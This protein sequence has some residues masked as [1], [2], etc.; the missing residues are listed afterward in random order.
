MQVPR[1]DLRPASF[2]GVPFGVT[3]D[4][5]DT[6]RR[7]VKHE[8]PGREKPYVEDLGRKTRG[9]SIEAFVVGADYADR[10]NELL[11]ALE[12][13]GSGTLI[14][15]YYGELTVQVEEVSVKHS[16]LDGGMAIFSITFV[17]PGS[18]TFAF[19]ARNTAANVETA[20]D[21]VLSA[22]GAAYQ[23]VYATIPHDHS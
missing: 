4:S 20:A 12:E 18:A 17:E 9:F 5:L 8:F 3:S 19:S 21:G 1:T 23:G 22:A 16:A 7:T 10:R 11:T 2:R 15:P 6:G 14:H 13:P